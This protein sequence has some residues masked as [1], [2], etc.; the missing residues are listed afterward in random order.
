MREKMSL[1]V[2]TKTSLIYWLV[3]ADVGRRGG[4]GGRTGEERSHVSRVEMGS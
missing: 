3:C 2:L 1:S 4:G